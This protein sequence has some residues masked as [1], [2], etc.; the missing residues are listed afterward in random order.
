[1]NFNVREKIWNLQLCAP[2]ADMSGFDA[3]SFL[4]LTEATQQK[5]L[6]E[7]FDTGFG[8]RHTFVSRSITEVLQ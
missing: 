2:N 4:T 3:L 5:L 8:G 7:G 1:M 6:P